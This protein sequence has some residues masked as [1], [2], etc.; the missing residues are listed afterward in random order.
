MIALSDDITIKLLGLERNLWTQ[1]DD[2]EQGK[3]KNVMYAY[4]IFLALS[5]ISSIFFIYMI[6]NALLSAFIV[7]IMMSF[8][9]GSIV[10]FSLIIFR[11]SIFDKLHEKQKKDKQ[12]LPSVIHIE[13]SSTL[14]NENVNNANE[15][16]QVN[17]P[18]KSAV[19]LD[20][21]STTFKKIK[22]PQFS[23]NSKVPG[24]AGFIRF[25]ILAI[26]GLL[27]IFPLSCLLH[28][29]TIQELNE[30]IGNAYIEQY[31]KDLKTQFEKNNQ[32][33]NSQ[34]E[35]VKSD[36]KENASVYQSDG[37][38]R[39]KNAELEE[40]SQKLSAFTSDFN[41]RSDQDI[42]HYKTIMQGKY[43]I[44]ADF[45]T[46]VKLPFFLLCF[47]LIASLL[48][49]THFLLFRLK[50]VDSFQY[51]KLSTNHYRSIIDAEYTI[52]EKEGY[53]YLE[54]VYGYTETKFREDPYWQNPPYKT[55]PR[56]RFKSRKAISKDDFNKIILSTVDK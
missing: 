7:G 12:V 4:F 15:I 19:L 52:T 21:I 47:I 56:E 27:V 37:M 16:K 41:S 23:K 26:M 45:K 11:R 53:A 18:G 39:Q 42:E 28:L 40:L 8:V 22:F 55:I 49:Y 51:S 29:T 6:L 20:K 25:S 35:K 32:K 31:E 44:A 34:I 30:K 13:H 9:I 14:K 5:V 17:L 48:I 2:S 3:Y 1:I 50:T 43:F 36:L 38:L 24:L 10:R 54:A 46:V 33:I